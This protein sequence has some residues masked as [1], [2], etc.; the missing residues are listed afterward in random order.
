MRKDATT[1]PGQLPHLV[2]LL[3]DETP[4]VREGVTRA[5]LNLG[6]SIESEI[7]R[8]KLVLTK[9]QQSALNS[10]LEE[11][12]R[13]WMRDQW[14]EWQRMPEGIPKLEHG[15]CLISAFME[16]PHTL[17]R[18]SF[19]LDELA[20]SYRAFDS[21]PSESALAEYLFKREGF[22]G[23]RRDYEVPHNS[24]LAWVIEHRQ[25]IPISL[26]TVYMLVGHRIGLTIHGC[27]YPGHFLCRITIDKTIHLVDCFN[28]GRVVDVDHAPGIT[29]EISP[30]IRRMV[31]QA[32][33]ATDILQRALRN[34]VRAYE[35]TAQPTQEAFMKELLD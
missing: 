2:R 33:S 1:P 34:L 21:A 29:P 5:L 4:M 27:N 9:T 28:G 24:N 17:G 26:C 23:A 25:G 3:D 10:I 30:S 22:S 32:P 20:V 18:V 14:T 6:T 16:G 19:L 8:Q 13:N 31:R 7:V 11:L 12:N 15:W 35:Q